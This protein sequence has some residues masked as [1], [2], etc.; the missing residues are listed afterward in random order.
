MESSSQKG[1]G[2]KKITEVKTLAVP[3]ALGE[4]KENITVT[5]NQFSKFSKEQLIKQ[6]FKFHSQGNTLEAAQYYQRFINQG[7]KDYRVFSNFG[8]ILQSLGNLKEAELSYRKAIEI[9]PDFADSNYNLGTTLQALG[10]LKEAELSYLKAIEINPDFAEAHNNLGIILND[11]GKLQ[12]AELSYRKA[13]KLNPNFADAHNNLGN[14]LKELGN[15]KEAELSI[16]KAIELKPDFA[17][18]HYNLGNLLKELGNLKEAELSIRKAIELKTNFAEAHSN[19]GSILIDLGKLQDAELSTRKAIQL[20]PN[21]AE[22]HSNLGNILSDLGKLQDAELSTRKAIQLNPNYAEAH[23]NL[24]N[25]LSDLDKSQEAFNSYL[26]AIDI[27]PTLS[28]IY[29]TITRFLKYSDPSQLNKSKLKY[30]LNL[31]LERNDISHKELFYSFK[32]AYSNELINNLEKLDSDI[33]QIDLIINDKVI[34]NALKKI[35]FTD[36]ELETLL[37]KIRRNICNLISKDIK[38]INYSQLQFI[39]TLGEQCFFNEY[40]YSVTEEENISI[41]TI[42]N[43]CIDG[44]LSETNVSILSCYFPLY[45]LLNR[46]PLLKSFTSYHQSFKELIKL[47]IIEPLNEI[48]LSKNIKKLGSIN[49][50]IS[51]K[52]KSQYEENPYPRWRYSSHQTNQKISIIQA[53]NNEII[54]NYIKQNIDNHQLT[55]L[56]AGCGTGQQILQSQR[57]KNAQVTAIDLSLSSLAYAQR[58][59]NELGITNVELIQ[60]DILEVSLLK[61]KFDVIECG[62]VLHHMNDPSQG[63]KALVSVLKN[64]GFLKLGLYSRIA[65][66]DVIAAAQHISSRNL[67]PT[68]ENIHLFREEVFSGK[69]P[70]NKDFVNF[71]DFYSSSEVRD[72]FFHYQA[73]YIYLSQLEEILKQ[74]SLK[75]LG[76]LLPQQIKSLY[77]NY[78]PEDKKQT[79]LQNWATFEEK[80]PNTFRGMYQFWVSKISI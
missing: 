69:Y 49:D 42:I 9:K 19:L 5:T 32:F 10:N 34:I 1:E 72:F 29:T 21:Y 39:I 35:I 4:N 80:H 33:S 36:Q 57:Y 46:I 61:R 62:G 11:V 48:E 68:L 43:R 27:N 23:S 12:E 16:R 65:I 30:I 44:E 15:L 59:V 40:I 52:V 75:F 37:T 79:N 50:D 26:K 47:Q 45:K 8:T 60:M 76:F 67:D 63:L 18:A 53:I 77:K 66:K 28:N 71:N 2:K 41:N 22:A 54:P 55:I 25:I 74:R 17:N 31:L 6:A 20:N 13:L 38:S 64:N 3:F 24:G 70:G 56:I 14:L 73:H 7:F 78:F 51:Q 58:K